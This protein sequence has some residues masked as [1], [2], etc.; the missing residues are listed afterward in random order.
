MQFIIHTN[1][2]VTRNGSFLSAFKNR[3]KDVEGREFLKSICK[4]GYTDVVCTLKMYKLIYH[5]SIFLLQ[6]PANF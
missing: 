2:F 1:C 6:K 3:E 5:T 4:N